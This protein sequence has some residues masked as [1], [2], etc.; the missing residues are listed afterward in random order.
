MYGENGLANHAAACAYGF[1]LSMAPMLLLVAFLI[2]FAFGSSPRAII[3]LLSAIP[4]LGDFFDEKW[5][6]SDFFIFSRPGIPGIISVFFII[7]AG[8]ILALSIQRG[9]NAVFPESKKRSPVKNAMITFVIEVSVIIFVFAVIIFSRTAMRFYSLFDFSFRIPILNF[10]NTH[11]RG[12]V[13]YIT[14][15]GIASYCFYRFLPVNPPRKLSAFQGAIFCS[16][17]YSLAVIILAIILNRTRYNF[18]YGTFGNLIII[19]INVYFFFSFFFIGAQLAFVTDFYEAVLFSRLRRYNLKT[20]ERKKSS[21]FFENFRYS[22]LVYKIFHPSKS[23]LKKYFRYYKK[24]EIVFSHEDKNEI[25]EK[26]FYLFEGEAE[27]TISSPDGSESYNSIITSDSFFGGMGYLISGEQTA[28]VRAKSDVSVITIPPA[29]F[30][31]I[32]K[33]DNNLDET[34]IE[35]MSRNFG[36]NK[37]TD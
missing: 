15:L 31:L 26:I 18:L 35:H 10:L 1:L 21:G 24:G 2:F 4:F 37:K 13:V 12:Q 7:W 29:L 22:V 25:V 5:L 36:M 16:F 27:I 17:A 33:Y 30:S 23:K 19:L 32:L 6:S 11:F 14:L 20:I 34:L 9:L 8:R 3:V 28:I